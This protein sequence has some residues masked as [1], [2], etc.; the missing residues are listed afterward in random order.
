MT[1]EEYEERRGNLTREIRS[2]MEERKVA[3]ESGDRLGDLEA[4]GE[5]SVLMAQVDALDREYRLV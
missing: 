2:A 3:A 5:I 1:R 4:Q